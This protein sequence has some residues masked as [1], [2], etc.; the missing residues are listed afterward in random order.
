[1]DQ[2]DR[3]S[4]NITK[5]DN[6]KRS[7]AIGREGDEGVT[8]AYKIRQRGQMGPKSLQKDI[9]VYKWHKRT[10]KELA[11]STTSLLG[12]GVRDG[13]VNEGVRGRL[14]LLDELVGGIGDLHDVLGELG[15][16]LELLLLGL[17][18]LELGVRHVR[19]KSIE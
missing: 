2:R 17:K 16:V 10:L 18:A 14:D 13:R 5:I 12:V 4:N 15:L 11:T 3:K 7:G 19:W 6:K 1:M 9:I 8:K